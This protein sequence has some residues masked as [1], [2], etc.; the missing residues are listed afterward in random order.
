MTKILLILSVFL[1]AITPFQECNAQ[2]KK[3]K[4]FLIIG[5]VVESLGHN[6]LKG[7]KVRLLDSSFSC[8]DSTFTQNVFSGYSSSSGKSQPAKFRLKMS[9]KPGQ[10]YLSLEIDK[11]TP[12]LKP[13]EIRHIGSREVFLDV[14]SI[15]LKRSPKQL[16]EIVVTAT[17]VKFYNKGDTLVFNADA[18]E[19]AEGSMLDALVSQLPGVELKENGQIYVNGRFVENLLLNGKDFFKGDNSIMLDNLGSYMVKDV[20]VYEK[21][22]A[23]NEFAGRDVEKKDFVMDVRLKKEYRRGWI[24]NVE[25]GGGTNSRYL[26]RMFGMHYTDF[27]RIALFANINNLN[28]NQRP[29]QAGGFDPSKIQPGSRRHQNV[30]LTYN[31]DTRNGKINSEGNIIWSHTSLTDNAT[32]SRTNFLPGRDNYDYSFLNSRSS[33]H[34]IRLISNTYLTFK[35]VKSS[36]SPFLEYISY[37]NNSDNIS[38]TF[39]EEQQN[40]TRE[41]LESLYSAEDAPGLGDIVNRTAIKQRGKGYNLKTELSWYNWIKVPHTQDMLHLSAKGIYGQSHSRS[42]TGYNINTGADPTPTTSLGQ[43][44]DSRPNRDYQLNAGVRYDFRASFGNLQASYEFTHSSR[45]KNRLTHELE[46]LT[47]MGVFGVAVPDEAVY[48]PDDS[49][50]STLLTNA[51][52]IGLRA[53][54]PL[55]NKLQFNIEGGVQMFNDNLRY[56]RADVPYRKSRSSIIPWIKE[57]TVLFNFGSKIQSSYGMIRRCQMKLDYKLNAKRPELEWLLPITDS[58]DPMNILEGAESLHNQLNHASKLEFTYRASR[59]LNHLLSLTYNIQRNTLVR[60]YTYDTTTGVRHWRSYN[61]SGNWTKGA[62]SVLSLQ[63]GP[64]RAMTLSNNAEV[65]YG[66]ASDMIGT[67]VDVPAQSTIR[68]TF[69]SD[70]LRLNYQIARQSIGLKGEVLWRHTRGTREGF[71]TIN[72]TAFNCGLTGTFK[73]PFDFGLSTDFTIYTRRGYNDPGLDRSDLVWNARLSR[74]LMKGRWVLML[75]GFDLLHR[76]SNVTYSINAQGRTVTYTNT[77]PRYVL[78]HV[79]YRIDVKPKKL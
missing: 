1:A 5:E 32:T 45:G 13:L 12:L 53:V 3:E 7:T 33:D 39:N 22:S 49:Y 41:L 42:F 68:N 10:Y 18:F 47:D 14:G 61:T 38:A 65:T 23:M 30:G 20:A 58:T 50:W 69:I 70:K 35:T 44:G 55:W 79:I 6:P 62:S 8:I 26:G 29:G 2:N 57:A 25:A 64:K 28:D 67:D 51:H 36:V 34:L 74:S 37:K 21:S 71:N 31:V 27:S 54:I 60:G 56:T 76:L 16:K 46:H 43:W 66:H 73:L 72:A 59:Y 11:Y 4:P 24:A 78:F 48:S 17:K 15:E 77:L 19:L 52:E 9:R 75:D 40:V 63:F